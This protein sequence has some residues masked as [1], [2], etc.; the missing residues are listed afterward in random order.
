MIVKYPQWFN[1]V[2]AGVRADDYLLHYSDKDRLRII[3]NDRFRDHGE[4]F[5]WLAVD[6]QNPNS[7]LIKYNIVHDS[8]VLLPLEIEERL[9]D[10]AS[11]ASVELAKQL[12]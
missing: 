5:S 7:R 8:I 9:R 12:S 1:E 4:K 11:T 3:S 6:N 10:D 2:P